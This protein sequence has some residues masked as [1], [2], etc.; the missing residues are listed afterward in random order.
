MFA[1]GLI[2]YT[3]VDDVEQLKHKLETYIIYEQWCWHLWRS[4]PQAYL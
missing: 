1:D 2:I 4:I 3:S